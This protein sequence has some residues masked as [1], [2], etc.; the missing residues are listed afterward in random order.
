MNNA[1]M[2]ATG[3]NA[4]GTPLDFFADMERR[5][6]GF[7]CDVAADQMLTLC[8]SW[9]GPDHLDPSRRDCLAVDWPTDKPN[10]LNPPYGDSEM[11][12]RRLKSGLLRCDK[13]RCRQRGFHT[14]VYIPGCIDFVRKAEQQRLRGAETWALLAARTDVE[15]F[16]EYIWDNERHAPRL[17]RSVEFLR[18]RLTFRRNGEPDP[19]PF[20]SMVVIFRPTRGA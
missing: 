3:N 10:W 4:T 11:P 7:G 8:P 13:K 5:S 12:C 14:D 17:G 20:P 19:A 1:L 16:H 2:F 9:F 15:W 6:G 18:G